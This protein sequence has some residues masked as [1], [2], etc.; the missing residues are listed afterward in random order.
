MV[1]N[2]QQSLIDL[3]LLSETSSSYVCE[4]ICPLG[5]SDHAG[6]TLSKRMCHN[7][8]CKISRVRMVWILYKFANF[9]KAKNLSLSTN[10]D[11]ILSDSIDL[12]VENWHNQL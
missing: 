5:N 9:I 7:G 11:M 2:R 3:T 8:A 4:T 12:S 10:W 6:I 1:P